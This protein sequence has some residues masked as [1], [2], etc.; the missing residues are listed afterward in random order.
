MRGTRFY[1]LIAAFLIAGFIFL[2]LP[3][4]GFSGLAPIECC[5]LEGSCS[6]T[7]TACPG[8]FI[9]GAFC[10]EE[11]GLCQA[12]PRDIP[13]LSEWAL[14]ATAGILGIAGFIIIRRR[15]ATA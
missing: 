7:A 10:N 4:E 13:T 5:Q 9:P 12:E 15:K 8:E 3:E 14:I 1:T 11:T 2:A 6:D